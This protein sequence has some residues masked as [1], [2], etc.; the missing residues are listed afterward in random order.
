MRSCRFDYQGQTLFGRLFDDEVEPFTADQEG[1]ANALPKR[2]PLKSIRLL[3]PVSGG[4]IFGIG[5]NYAAHVQ[6]LN[7]GFKQESPLV[8]MK[9][10]TACIGQD[11]VILLPDVGRIDYEGE[12]A[13]V[14]GRGGRHIPEHQA[15]D[16]VLGLTCAN[17]ISA[18]DL[19]KSDGQWVRAKGFDTFCPLGP[20]I[21][22]DVHPGDLGIVTRLNGKVVQE[23]RTSDMSR[24]PAELI[25]FLS[26]FCTLI[27]GDIILTGTPAGVGPLA[28]GDRIEV[29]I[30]SIAC[31]RNT[32][33][34]APHPEP[35]TP[36]P[37]GE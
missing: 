2:L 36:Q 8:F 12:L 30:E 25:A 35:L 4:R 10:E 9:P 31:L 15:L 3:P 16:H 11:D 23:G 7:P 21:E 1:Q 32:V 33:A 26:S 5:R 27:P 20:W 6:E 28:S 34:D 17:D 37:R 22:H 24:S 14:I 18:R 19:Q 13:V 29:E